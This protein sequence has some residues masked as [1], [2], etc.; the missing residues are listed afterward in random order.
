MFRIL[1]LLTQ[2]SLV[3]FLLVLTAGQAAARC[4]GTDLIKAMPDHERE[5]L[6][7]R[8]GRMPYPEGLLWHAVRGN[9][10]ITLFGT[11]H[12]RH[13][14]TDAHL[15]AL[16]PFIDA[17]DSVWL[18][19]SNDDTRALQ[20]RMAEDPSLMFLTSGPTLIDLLGDEDWEKLATEFRARGIPPVIASRFKPIWAAMLLGVGP[21]EAQAGVFEAKGIDELIGA[22]AA[23]NGNPSR[24]LED[25]VAILG[26]L[27][28]FPQEKQLD[29][30]R[31]FFD[32][33]VDP[34]DLSHTMKARY[35]AGQ[36][37]LL[38]EF[39]RKISLEHG[40]ATAAEDF[41]TFET[42]FLDARNRDWASRMTRKDFSGDIFIAV[43]AAHLPGDTGVLNLLANEGFAITRLPFAP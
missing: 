15:A 16:A 7:D 42:A 30:L 2:L 17:A 38:W 6:L 12:F 36:T 26:L 4:A 18:E 27:D 20:K 24:S 35:L 22:R 10:R 28:S 33:D 19:V 25:A 31:L 13:D 11:Y 41:A 32:F 21:C 9:T 40:G 29:M 3:A 23:A 39:S 8:A 5:T 34:D 43:G 37:A 14:R 1:P